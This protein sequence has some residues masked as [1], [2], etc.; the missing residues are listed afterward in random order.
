MQ[1][2]IPMI[3]R[4][5]VHKFNA[6][7]DEIVPSWM[8]NDTISNFNILKSIFNI[9]EIISAPGPVWLIIFECQP[10]YVDFKLRYL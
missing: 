6:L 8:C 9:S 1:T 4:L 2:K 3:V 5:T 7:L 10:S